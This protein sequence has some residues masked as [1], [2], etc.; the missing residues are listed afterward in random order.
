MIEQTWTYQD[1]VLKVIEDNDLWKYMDKPGRMLAE[2]R[3]IRK[4]D[5]DMADLVKC[6]KLSIRG[7]LPDRA[8]FPDAYADVVP[9]KYYDYPFPGTIMRGQNID[10][11]DWIIDQEAKSVFVFALENTCADPFDPKNKEAFERMKGLN[12]QERI[13]IAQGSYVRM[14]RGTQDKITIG[15]NCAVRFTLFDDP[16]LPRK[17]PNTKLVKYDHSNPKHNPE[18]RMDRGYPLMS[19]YVEDESGVAVENR[20]VMSDAKAKKG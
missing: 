10:N 7:K 17:F 11:A 5:P 19:A 3:K 4:S 14:T 18:L 2:Y 15:P 13:E 8:Q 9:K 6:V 16:E 20:T 12:M 1:A